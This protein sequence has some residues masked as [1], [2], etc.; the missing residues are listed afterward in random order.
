MTSSNE[1][2]SLIS[3]KIR[4]K[5]AEYE[6]CVNTSTERHRYT[7]TGR[8]RIAEVL[9]GWVQIDHVNPPAHRLAVL[10]QTGAVGGLHSNDSKLEHAISS[11]IFPSRSNIRFNPFRSG[12]IPL[13]SGSTH[14]DQARY[15]EYVSVHSYLTPA[16]L[17]K[18]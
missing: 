18:P 7:L 1:M 3:T 10:E 15:P 2:S 9:C 12:E 17:T 16:N 13:T 8:Y 4:P 6:A 14:F 11:R 5:E